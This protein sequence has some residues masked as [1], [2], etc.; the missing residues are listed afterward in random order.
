VVTSIESDS[1][2]HG[3]MTKKNQIMNSVHTSNESLQRRRVSLRVV[4]IIES[5]CSVQDDMTELTQ[6]LNSL[7]KTNDSF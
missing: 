5:D 1:S 7:Q 3:D 4:T 2:N 6:I